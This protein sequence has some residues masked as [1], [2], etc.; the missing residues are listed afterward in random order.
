[1]AGGQGGV[2]ARGPGGATRPTC[3]KAT[4]LLRRARGPECRRR[5]ARPGCQEVGARPANDRFPESLALGRYAPASSARPGAQAWVRSHR[6]H[7][8]GGGFVS[9][10][11]TCT[12]AT[13]P[14]PLLSA[15]DPQRAPRPQPRPRELCGEPR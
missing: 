2:W 15:R 12:R 1:M 5:L 8:A 3:P 7:E 6:G 10:G 4:P 13:T 14:P 9:P 11:R